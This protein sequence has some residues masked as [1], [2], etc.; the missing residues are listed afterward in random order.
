MT[1]SE[2]LLSGTPART[3]LRLAL[4]LELSPRRLGSFEDWM[5]LMATEGAARGHTV[6]IFTRGPIHPVV[7]E[8]LEQ[9]GAGWYELDSIERRPLVSSRRLARRYDVIHLTLFAPRSRVSLAAYAAWPARVAFIDQF[10]DVGDWTPPKFRPRDLVSSL[11]DRA[12]MRRLGAMA[13]VS[14]Y[15]TSRDRLRFGSQKLRTLYNGVRVDRYQPRSSLRAPSEAVVVFVAAWLIPEKGIDILLRAFAQT[16]GT[17]VRLQV[18]GDGPDEGRLR[19]LAIEL[20]IAER[21]SF[22]GL[23]NDLPDLLA[24]ADIFVHP[25]TWAEAFGFAVAEA[26]SCG[27]AVVAA[28]VG[29]M[30][31]LI[32]DGT[33]G[34]LF[35]P[36]DPDALAAQLNRLIEDRTLRE[37]LSAN[38]R[39]RVVERFSMSSSVRQHLDLCEEIASGDAS[40]KRAPAPAQ[41]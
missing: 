38:A 6:D 10:S 24:D 9:A 3:P 5:V 4:F 40:P 28:S 39:A 27:C 17:E 21:T 31:E 14:D 23:R 37:L 34:L 13:G 35:A 8:R 36:G 16:R 1:A 11:L 22:L 20:G 33:S 18:A 41:E 30:P 15:V 29:A 26:M 25:A 12:M 19:A 7:A 32:E 2:S